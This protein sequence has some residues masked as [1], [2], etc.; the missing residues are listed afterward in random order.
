MCSKICYFLSRW[1]LVISTA[2][3]LLFGAAI[4]RK[5]S[6]VVFSKYLI[7][8]SVGLCVMLA[9]SCLDYLEI[10]RYHAFLILGT[11]LLLILCIFAGE[12]IYGVRR[13]LNV[14]GFSFD[15]SD[16]SMLGILP[17][18]C[19]IYHQKN[20]GWLAIFNLF[21]VLAVFAALLLLLPSLP[22]V[23]T[24]VSCTVGVLVMAILRKHLD[25]DE[26]SEK[27]LIPLEGASILLAGGIT[28]LIKTSP[29][30]T[31]RIEVFI[32]RGASDPYGGGWQPMMASKWLS[33]AHFWGPTRSMLNTLPDSSNGYILVNLI[34]NFGWLAGIAVI[35][36][37]LVFIAD[38][39]KKTYKIKDPGGFFLAFAASL[40]L[41]F[42]FLAGILMNFNFFP[43][44]SWSIPL[45]SYAPTAFISNMALIGVVLSVSRY[46]RI[47][48]D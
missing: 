13:W 15:M 9:V 19:L 17:I 47:A 29:Y 16:L 21:A 26:T 22:G 31:R 2:A 46:D 37:I 23:F 14:F 33:A 45:L 40:L 39:F 41:S 12:K 10:L 30:I 48:Q 35:L 5:H 44:A 11:L 18:S 32:S 28:F 1:T 38:L 7:S 36:L 8:A 24:I 6:P 3:I 27:F 20:Q 4:M 34:S 42:R 43:S 25:E